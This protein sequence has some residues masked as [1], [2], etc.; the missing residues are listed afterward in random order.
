MFCKH[1]LGFDEKSK[2]KAVSASTTTDRLVSTSDILEFFPKLHRSHR[3][4]KFLWQ[5][6]RMKQIEIQVSAFFTVIFLIYNKEMCKKWTKNF[7]THV[8]TDVQLESKI[9]NLINEF[10]PKTASSFGTFTRRQL[11]TQQRN[12]V[13]HERTF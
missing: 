9:S 8:F 6:G 2:S 3:P 5:M 13:F 7:Y 1:K 4:G 12:G 10:I 11:K